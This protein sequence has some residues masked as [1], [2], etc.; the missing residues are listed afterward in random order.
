MRSPDVVVEY[1]KPRLALVAAFKPRDDDD[2]P[3]RPGGV[4]M[5]LRS[6]RSWPD[7]RGSYERKGR[8]RSW[9]AAS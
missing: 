8:I 5:R 4:P 1:R 9:R 7:Q 3:P 2:P 6:G